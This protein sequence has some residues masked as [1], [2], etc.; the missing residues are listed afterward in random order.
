ML[1]EEFDALVRRLDT[2]GDT[3]RTA[4]LGEEE[5]GRLT[6]EQAA[7]L[8]EIY[9]WNRLIRLPERE[10]AFFDWLRREDEPI[11]NDLWGGEEEPY[12]V[13]LGYLLDLTPKRRGFSICDLTE[14]QNFYFT[15]E[16]IS[17]EE[18]KPLVD[19]S[20]DII[21]AEGRL[22]MDQAFL[23]EVWRAPIDQWRFAYMYKVPLAEVKKMVLWLL[24]EGIL[25]L[26]EENEES[27][28]QSDSAE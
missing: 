4:D 2:P 11:W 18:G 7:R 6:Q 23:V 17:P 13:S 20:L 21:A 19:A 10:R 3:V 14:H 9:G 8:V 16:N 12:I 27:A 25:V 5:I 24:S 1:Q 26:S 15:Q 28:E 22:S